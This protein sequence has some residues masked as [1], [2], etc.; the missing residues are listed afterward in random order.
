MCPKLTQC[1][2]AY[3]LHSFCPIEQYDIL[4]GSRKAYF[5]IATQH[6]VTLSSPSD[7]SVANSVT[8]P[9]R[10]VDPTTLKMY[11]E[12]V[13]GNDDIFS[14]SMQCIEEKKGFS[15]F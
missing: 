4:V 8:D 10:V 5:Y 7:F 1:D 13:E 15:L 14:S 3:I 9:N 6:D 12:E 2:N 11:D